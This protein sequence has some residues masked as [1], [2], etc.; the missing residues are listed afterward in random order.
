[1]AG[2][3]DEVPSFFDLGAWTTQLLLPLFYFFRNENVAPALALLIFIAALA[4]CGLFLLQ[5]TFIRSQVRARI[6]AV[7]RTGDKAG[8][9]EAMPEIEKLMLRTAYLRHS[10]QKFRETLIEPASDE[11]SAN[12]VVLNTDRPHNYFNM[13]DTGRCQ[14]F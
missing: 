12:R 1:M 9:A 2:I 8:F 7:S 10:W 13:G 5:S 11:R 14:I 6:R 4:L 3:F